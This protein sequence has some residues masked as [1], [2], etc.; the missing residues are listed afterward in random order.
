MRGMNVVTRWEGGG[1]EE[2]AATP[3]RGSHGET[4]A[5][6]GTNRALGGGGVLFIM[7]RRDCIPPVQRAPVLC[8]TGKP[9]QSTIGSPR[10]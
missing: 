6:R 3:A 5:W 1:A 9:A 4:G 7:Q 8:C 2:A 10:G